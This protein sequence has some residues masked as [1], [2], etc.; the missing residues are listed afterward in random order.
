MY[1]ELLVIFLILSGIA[2]AFI[3]GRLWNETPR[4]TNRVVKVKEYDE[5]NEEII[6]DFAQE[7]KKRMKALRQFSQQMDKKAPGEGG[8]LKI[9]KMSGRMD[10][11]LSL[12]AAFAKLSDTELEEESVLLV[13]CIYEALEEMEKKGQPRPDV[14]IDNIQACKGDE[15]LLTRFFLILFRNTVAPAGPTTIEIGGLEG[16]RGGFGKFFITVKPVPQGIDPANPF[17]LYNNSGIK[18]AGLGRGLAFC[19]KIA[20]LHG[21][22]LWCQEGHDQS[23]TFWVSL[24]VPADTPKTL[25]R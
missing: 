10:N 7:M 21:G 13:D 15:K 4:T 9:E 19:K 5:V 23:M 18:P 24:P 1:E 16:E 6:G 3:I 14:I 17:T 11:M 25:K 8:L 22:N 12:L 2:A 20:A